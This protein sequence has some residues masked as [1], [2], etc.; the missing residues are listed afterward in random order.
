MPDPVIEAVNKWREFA[1]NT[2]VMWNG[3][4]RTWQAHI[5]GSG[6]T[7]EER[8][9]QPTVFPA[10]ASKILDFEVGLSLAP[11][12]TGEEGK[13]DF[14]PADSVTHPFVFE[15][16]GTSEGAALLGHEGQV[17]RY[18]RDGRPRIR[19]V[20]LTNL[21]GV[22]IFEL[23]DMGRVIETAAID[24]RGLLLGSPATAASTKSARLF[25]DFIRF[26]ARRDLT[27]DEKLHRIRAAPA[28]NS[29]VEVTSSSWLLGRL[30]SVVQLLTADV[31]AQIAAEAL[32]NPAAITDDEQARVLEE[33]RALG[34]RL[35]LATAAEKTSL[36]QFV[37]A[38]TVSPAGKAMSQYAAHVAYYTATRLML[39]RVWEDLNLLEPMLY[40]GG[41]DRQM[42]RF[43]NIIQDVV[44]QSFRRARGRYRSL[45]ERNNNYSW[46][47]P[48]GNT[49]VET[50]YELANTYFGAIESDVLGQV[51]ERMLERIDRKLLGQYY[52]PRDIIRLI[53]DLID[54]DIITDI[55][56]SE[57][58]QPRVL[59]IATGS[60]GFLVEKAARLRRRFVTQRKAGASINPQTWLNLV[61]DGLN[62]V[63]V[64]RFSAYLAELN[65][66]VQLGRVI[67]EDARLRLPPLGIIATDTLSLHEGIE[68]DGGTSDLDTASLPSDR[69]SRAKR[70][71]DATSG[72]FLM[73]VACG[74]PP[75]IGQKVGAG[76]MA[77]TRIAHPYW[78][79]FAGEHMDYL[80]WFLILGISKL[81]E[82]GRFG[83]ITTEYW[84]RSAGARPLRRYLAERCEID[85]IVLF[86]D[87]RLF[88]GAPGQHSM[89][90]VGSRA[91]PPE[92]LLD[93]DHQ[94]P[95]RKPVVTV[96]GGGSL[97]ERERVGLLNAIRAGKS[98]RRASATTFTA[99]V[100]P[101]AL[102]EE[103][104]SEVVLTREQVRRRRT[105]RA[106]SRTL[107]LDTDEGVLSSADRMRA[108]YE[109]Q[110]PAATLRSIEWPSKKAGIFALTPEEVHRLGQLN[111]AEDKILR[112]LVNTRDVL[113]YAAVVA[114]NASS[115]IYL[116][117]PQY[118]T[119]MSVAERRAIPFPTGLPTVEQHLKQFKPLLQQKVESYQERRPWWCL[120][121]ARPDIMNRSVD[122]PWMDYC[123]TT[124]W[125]GGERLVV[126]LPP[127]GSVPA[128]GLQALIPRN[129]VP[130][131]YVCGL[132][133]STAVQD[134]AETLPPGNVTAT[135]IREL[136]LPLLPEH[137][138]VIASTTK[139]LASLVTQLAT[140]HSEVYPLIV[141]ALL[142]DISLAAL[143]LD[144]WLA[145]VGPATKWGRL[146]GISWT[147]GLDIRGSLNQPIVDI[148]VTDDLY[149]IAVSAKGAKGTAAVTVHVDGDD[150]D[151][152]HTLAMYLRGAAVGRRKLADVADLGVPTDPHALLSARATDEAALL[153]AVD[154]Y[155]SM[156]QSIDEIV[157]N[158][159]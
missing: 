152:A 106:N 143:P 133:N 53:W 47:E 52:T 159:I 11:E 109:E 127:N 24:L 126:G 146:A 8:L 121:R 40:D 25:A 56:E 89:I 111:R 20:V 158:A 103:S 26:F 151:V 35:G 92:S 117:P 69:I 61:S 125:G 134:L 14:T 128:S 141:A 132:M 97:S 44:E 140:V 107:T 153:A 28:W 78:S 42:T 63:E 9:I 112:P 66:L 148:D 49:Y 84:L 5:S 120:H 123:L 82:G 36:R 113:P 4:R 55:A 150:P 87:L 114:K 119:G 2:Y 115:M 59:D 57:D 31:R 7:D 16:K 37:T 74:N 154:S 21:V 62:G 156:R 65:L 27:N 34:T 105:L 122:G 131:T 75:Y 136:G 48:S 67:S 88:P 46:Y 71:K 85:R 155:R 22:R 101:N 39:V 149:G 72:D 142:E 124:R 23:D 29:V 145:R 70:L 1:S 33:L 100:S 10:F 116:A 12:E 102:L 60:G 144:S 18:L 139:K 81:R 104:W 96:Y 95:N 80:Y 45:F 157:D 51:Y 135:D 79:Q 76:M 99:A 118:A 137:I 98:G 94:P 138:A 147:H 13:P 3:R 38:D 129:D 50:I 17:G 77:R 54:S 64:Q 90:I 41:F 6:F 73:D 58:R 86:R 130:A 43:D 30:D 83:F 32:E 110:L 93:V 68:G 108:G 19:R 15:A 91:V